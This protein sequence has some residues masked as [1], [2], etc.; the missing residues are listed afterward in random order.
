MRG[1]E[2]WI[3]IG[4][5]VIIIISSQKERRGFSGELR[6]ID[7]CSTLGGLGWR[8]HEE[9]SKCSVI[10]IIPVRVLGGGKGVSR[11]RV[12]PSQ[13]S[14]GMGGGDRFKTGID[15]TLGEILMPQKWKRGNYR[16]IAASQTPISFASSSP[17]SMSQ[18]T[19]R[20][21]PAEYSTV[22]IFLEARN[23]LMGRRHVLHSA[24]LAGIAG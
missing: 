3:N 9:K 8:E 12:L 2:G 4:E 22:Q 21:A 19:L 7:R 5:E 17:P 6:A 18:S 23:E 1:R 11:R 15:P 16:R 20:L 10:I 14:I 13:Q 24:F